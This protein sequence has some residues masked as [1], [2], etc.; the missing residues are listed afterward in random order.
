M[1]VKKAL[2]IQ[3]EEVEFIEFTGTWSSVNEV[4]EFLNLKY[5]PIRML[6][7]NFAITLPLDSID[8]EA[9]PLDFY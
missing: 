5:I 3:T 8:N 2:H 1:K 4:K 7:N 9:Y 6:D